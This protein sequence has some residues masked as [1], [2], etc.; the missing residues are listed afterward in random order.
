M[1]FENYIDWRLDGD[2]SSTPIL[3]STIDFV[4]LVAMMESCWKAVVHDPYLISPST[5]MQ[6]HWI[7]PLPSFCIR[8][9]S[10]F[11]LS[12][13]SFNIHPSSVIM[14]FYHPSNSLLTIRYHNQPRLFVPG[15]LWPA[16]GFLEWYR[17]VPRPVVCPTVCLCGWSTE[18]R[19]NN[20]SLG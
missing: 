6:I 17:T 10:T 13:Y 14:S 12:R 15:I 7:W 11:L 8:S 18:R 1:L 16:V 9:Y 20:T 3:K 19:K 2:E 5:W 4:H